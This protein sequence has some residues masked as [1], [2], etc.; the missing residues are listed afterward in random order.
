MTTRRDLG[1]AAVAIAAAAVA[2]PARADGEA[3]V[4]DLYGRFLAA[5]NARDLAAVR[6]TLWASPKFLWVSDGRPFW[7]PDALVER[8]GAFQRAEVW[9]VDPAFERSRVVEVAPDAAFLSVPLVLTIGA[10]AAPARLAW[11]VGVLCRRG[12]DGW[13]IAALFTTEDKSG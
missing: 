13:R 10:A 11:L 5:Q 8:M 1:R 3:A 2:L 9:R 12:A 7:G 4:R 6:T